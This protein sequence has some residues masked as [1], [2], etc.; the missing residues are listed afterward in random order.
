MYR[1]QTIG[2][3][4]DVAAPPSVPTTSTVDAAPLALVALGGVIVG[5]LGFWAWGR[6]RK[7]GRRR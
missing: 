1:I 4:G 3:L 7:R 2:A 5:A 6:G